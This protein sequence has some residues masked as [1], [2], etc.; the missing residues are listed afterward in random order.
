MT[1]MKSLVVDRLGSL[2]DLRV[3]ETA[4]PELREGQIRVKVAACGL[5]FV[6]S[7]MIE[8]RYQIKPAVPF[9]PGS[10]VT[11]RVVETGPGVDASMNGRRVF[12][13]V[14]AGGFAD[15][16][17]AMA[18]RVLPIPD[19]LTDGQG[20]TFMQSYLT[21]WFAFTRRTQV[22]A[23]KTMLVLGA[24]G[25][26]GLAAVD[27][28]VALGLKVIAGASSAEKWQLGLDRGAFA[29]VDVINDDVKAKV[30]EIAGGVDIVYDP[31]GG[32]LAEPC[33]RAL[34]ANG[35]YM[36]VGFVAGIPRLP[37]NFVLLTNRTVVG[38]DWGAWV[39][40]NQAENQAM[41]VEVMANIVA[42]KLHP[43]EPVSYPMSRAVDAMRDLQ[44][45]KVAGKVALVPDF[46]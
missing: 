15:E 38:V 7:L 41:L 4:S 22:E 19:E 11:G 8:G 10:E 24:G 16:V 32:D 31:V 17:V 18:N 46:D 13:P 12:V 28:G 29:S 1:L 44:K 21:A 25:G 14:G 30:R 43:V 39:G 2:D 36:V 27:V 20:A 45:R 23:G 9:V 5:N 34:K 3:Q 33:L 42:G 40:Q 37:A 26:V 6:D 35:Q